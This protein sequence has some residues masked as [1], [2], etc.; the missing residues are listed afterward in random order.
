MTTEF[1]EAIGI[2]FSDEQMSTLFQLLYTGEMFGFT[3]CTSVDDVQR[4]CRQVRQYVT[5]AEEHP[6]TFFVDASGGV[7]E[8]RSPCLPL[9]ELRFDLAQNKVDVW[10]GGTA[11]DLQQTPVVLDTTLCVDA[12]TT[13]AVAR[14][15]AALCSRT[16][17]MLGL[18]HHVFVPRFDRM[19]DMDATITGMKQVA[20]AA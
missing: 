4:C 10:A 15:F 12:G 18:V 20:T 19:S 5:S 16:Y 11:D 6:Q 13:Y 9:V 8:V 3:K 2:Q 1:Q 17:K 14:G 7:Q